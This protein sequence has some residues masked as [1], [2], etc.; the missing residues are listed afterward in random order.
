[1]WVAE[2]TLNATDADFDLQILWND[3]PTRRF[4]HDPKGSRADIGM[5]PEGNDV[6]ADVPV[7]NDWKRRPVGNHSPGSKTS[8]RA[9]PHTP[10]RASQSYCPTSGHPQGPISLSAP[11][12]ASVILGRLPKS[13]TP[14]WATRPECVCCDPEAGNACPQCGPNGIPPRNG[15][16]CS[17]SVPSARTCHGLTPGRT[18]NC[19]PTTPRALLCPVERRS[20]RPS[21]PTRS[22]ACRKVRGH[23]VVRFAGYQCI[24]ATWSGLRSKVAV[25]A[26][27]EAGSCAAELKFMNTKRVPALAS[28]ASVPRPLNIRMCIRSLLF[29][30][31]IR[32]NCFESLHTDQLATP[33]L[34]RS[35]SVQRGIPIKKGR[36]K[37]DWMPATICTD[38]LP[39]NRPIAESFGDSLGLGVHNRISGAWGPLPS[40]QLLW[41]QKL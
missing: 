29:L 39:S 28:V 14:Y 1:M 35:P 23:S 8:C 22:P 20:C 37:H 9:L 33:I 31:G 10:S 26:G 3:G 2:T 7:R 11:W 17:R 12:L 13:P 27:L 21:I 5:R 38:G 40:V 16:L 30:F 32:A 19:R 4:H 34:G 6:R 24:S 36:R 18:R 25:A 15:T 41:E